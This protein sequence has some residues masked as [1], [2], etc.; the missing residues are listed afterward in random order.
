M[1]TAE[2]PCRK[3]LDDK[4]KKKRKAEAKAVANAP[5]VDIQVEKVTGKRGVGKEGTRKKRRVC[6]ETP[7]QPDSKHVSSL[8]HLNHT[9]PLEALANKEHVYTNASSGRMDV[10][11][12][13]ADEH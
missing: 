9:H 3:V 13:Q 4:K 1:V 2:I 12:N 8:V 5:D 11:R 6:M 7:M 10:L